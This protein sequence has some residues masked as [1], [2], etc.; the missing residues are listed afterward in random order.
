MPAYRELPFATINGS[1]KRCVSV[2]GNGSVRDRSKRSVS[3]TAKGRVS[4]R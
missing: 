3:D 1:N 4:E 2:A